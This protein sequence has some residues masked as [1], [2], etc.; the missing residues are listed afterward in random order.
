MDD[1]HDLDQALT[2]NYLA[3]ARAVIALAA[4][5][6]VATTH[7]QVMRSHVVRWLRDEN[8]RRVVSDE[9]AQ[10]WLKNERI[11][12][13]AFLRDGGGDLAR[14]AECYQYVKWA[15]ERTPSK[16]ILSKVMR[17]KTHRARTNKLEVRV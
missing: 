5:D 14:M 8:H 7:H 4:T 3:L 11:R 2:E 17:G 15:L 1:Q 9:F 12:V 10:A 16:N 13:G 6:Y